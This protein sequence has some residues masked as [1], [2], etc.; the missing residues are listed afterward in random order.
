[1]VNWRCK[2][3]VS[4]QPLRRNAGARSQHRACTRERGA[5]RTS[6]P[7]NCS[8]SDAGAQLLRRRTSARPQRLV[9]QRMR[10]GD[11]SY[12]VGHQHYHGILPCATEEEGREEEEDEGTSTELTSFSVLSALYLY[13]CL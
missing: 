9:W 8:E 1:M 4:A 6:C 2:P 11:M 13:R 3:D 5:W 7:K 10:A 12:N